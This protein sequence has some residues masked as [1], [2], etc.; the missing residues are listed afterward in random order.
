MTFQ[1]VDLIVR[2]AVS[3]IASHFKAEGFRAVTDMSGWSGGPIALFTRAGGQ[4]G[5]VFDRVD[6]QFDCYG[7]TRDQADDLCS[8]L[9][10][11]MHNLRGTLP[12][13][14][15]TRE[16]FGG[17]WM[18]EVTDDTTVPRFV[19]EWSVMCRPIEVSSS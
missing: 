2:D 3:E 12:F 6:V 10:A 5:G 13:V 16:N 19:S 4:L 15:G 11:L 7:D 17:M 18:P 8:N 9:R 14:V 1:P